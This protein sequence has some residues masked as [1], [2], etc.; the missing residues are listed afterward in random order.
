MDLRVGAENGGVADGPP[1]APLTGLK[2]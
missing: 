1:G 2:S